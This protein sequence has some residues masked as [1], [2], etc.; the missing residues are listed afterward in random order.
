MGLKQ[1]Q[2]FHTSCMCTINNANNVFPYLLLVLVIFTFVIVVRDRRLPSN[3]VCKFI[4]YRQDL[5]QQVCS[6][7]LNQPVGRPV[8]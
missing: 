4:A 1:E 5:C 8:P 7:Y 6:R 3:L 2:T